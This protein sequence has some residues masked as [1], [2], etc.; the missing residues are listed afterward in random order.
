MENLLSNNYYNKSKK[1]LF[2]SFEGGEGV[3]KSTQIELLKTS[4]TKK[5]I[6]V[7]STREPGGTK[8]GELIRK[9]LVSGEISSWDSYSESL[10]FNAL[11]REHIN[12]IINPSLFKGDIVL[13]DRFI[14]STIVYQGVGGGINQTLLLSL[15]KNF[16]YDLYPDITFFLSLDPKV[17]IDRT[18]SRN[19]KTENRF[20]NMGLSYHQKIQDGFKALSD[21]NNKRFFE[22]NAEL[23]VEK[24]SNQIYDH[25]ISIIK[26]ND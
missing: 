12:K 20:E 21:K 10:L 7:L 3:G 24:I 1:G 2:I 15:H 8:E 19:N 26:S 9:F 13:C 14:D 4:L 25:V 17:G 6:N 16:F 11:R 22:I 5:N 23:S 18:L